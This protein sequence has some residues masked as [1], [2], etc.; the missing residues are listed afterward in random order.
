MLMANKYQAFQWLFI[1]M[2]FVQH[3]DV[4][5]MIA[6]SDFACNYLLSS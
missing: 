3:D 2:L 1:G 5:A 4:L 6:S